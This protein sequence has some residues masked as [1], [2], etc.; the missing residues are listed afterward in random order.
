MNKQIEITGKKIFYRLYGDGKPVMLVHGFGETG[1]VWKNQVAFLKDSFQLIVPD[2][3][4]SG[5]S[6]MIDDMS[7][8]GMAEIL[9]EILDAERKPTQT[10]PKG[11]PPQ[12]PPKEGLPNTQS[13]LIETSN[14]KS[15]YKIS[16]SSQVSP[17]GGDLEGA[18]LVGHSMGGY[19]TLAFAK[20]YSHYLTAFGL[21]HSS[22]Y[23]DSE[24]KKGFRKKSIEFILKNGAFEFLKSTTPNLFSP[25]S[26]EQKPEMVDDFIRSLD[27][28]SASTLV[29]YYEAM[30]KRH[31]NTTLLKTT[32]LPVLFILGEHDNAVPLQDGLKQSHLPEKSYIHIL[33]QS[34]HMG[35]LEEENKSNDLLKK[36][37]SET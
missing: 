27:N 9:K 35:M 22:A 18:V 7:M 28:F 3:P 15:D 30:M 19:I 33:H 20:K 11:K 4:G 29:S 25:F 34:G 17:L 13:Q 10:L 24:E 32:S 8:E 36:F 5:Q 37:I 6:E 14:I 26:Q 21:F 12:T 31:D 2:L 1:E 23:A 16:E